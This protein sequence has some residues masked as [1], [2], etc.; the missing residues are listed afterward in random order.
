MYLVVDGER[1][2][3][4]AEVGVDAG[5]AEENLLVVWVELVGCFCVFERG[6]EVVG[7]DVGG[8]AVVVVGCVIGV[9][10]D[11]CS[12]MSVL[13][14]NVICQPDHGLVMYLLCI[15]A[16]HWYSPWP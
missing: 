6:G 2:I 5:E 9:C 4:P 12:P 15:P 8:G 7:G 16:R 11:C 1:F 14:L 13:Y 3:G 10:L